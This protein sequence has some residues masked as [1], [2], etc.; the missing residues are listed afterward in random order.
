MQALVKDDSEGRV[1]INF[2]LEKS[3]HRALK[4]LAT[5]RDT[6]IRNLLRE[7]IKRLISSSD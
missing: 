6:T 4:L 2:E 7:E 3:E 5:S 1:R